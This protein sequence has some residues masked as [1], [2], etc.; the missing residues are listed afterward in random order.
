[1]YSFN[2]SYG[3]VEL[4]DERVEGLAGAERVDAQLGGQDL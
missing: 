4:L 2:Y 3:P 1:M